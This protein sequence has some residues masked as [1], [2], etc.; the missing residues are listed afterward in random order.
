MLRLE[1]L[2]TRM[3][4]LLCGGAGITAKD[5]ERVRRR[6]ARPTSLEDVGGTFRA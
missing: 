4:V 1:R 6:R 5:V 3:M 2:L